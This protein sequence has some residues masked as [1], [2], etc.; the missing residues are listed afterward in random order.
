MAVDID[1]YELEYTTYINKASSF[2]Q[3][4]IKQRHPKKRRECEKVFRYDNNAERRHENE[5][6]SKK[7]IVQGFLSRVS[8]FYKIISTTNGKYN[9][10]KII[11]NLSHH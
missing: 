5:K 4:E 9:L 1:V 11:N 10:L 6:Q 3:P 7:K 2:N 8:V